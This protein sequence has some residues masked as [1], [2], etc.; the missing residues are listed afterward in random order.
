MSPYSLLP[1]TLQDGPGV[2][3]VQHNGFANDGFTLA[4]FPNVPLRIKVKDSIERWPA[5]FFAPGSIY[6]KTVDI[7]SQEIVGYSKWQLDPQLAESVKDRFGSKEVPAP[8]MKLERRDPVGL[9]DDLAETM[10]EKVLTVRNAVLGG[11]PHM[12]LSLISTIPS[13]RRRG[14]ASQHLAWGT[15]LADEY[16]LPIWL[17][18]SPASVSLY[19]KYGFMAVGTVES[20]LSFGSNGAASGSYIHTSMLREPSHL[21]LSE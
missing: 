6:L 1:V 10:T 20:D 18:A 19:K 14:V 21:K 7:D 16:H 3:S 13:H 15:K 12:L 4:S 9:N 5:N 8:E 17:D 2:A 11:R